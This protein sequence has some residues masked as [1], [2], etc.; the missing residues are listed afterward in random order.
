MKELESILGSND[1]FSVD[2]DDLGYISLVQHHVDSGDHTPIKQPPHRLSF[3]RSE[4]VSNLIDD[5]MKKGI[6][7]PSISAW[8]SLIVLVPKQQD[9]S[10]RFCVDYCKVNVTK[11]PLPRIDGI[12][13]T[14]GRSSYFTTLDLASGFW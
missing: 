14:L 1:V 7:Q 11:Y 2:D 6:I 9:N 12:L 10:V 4:T 3:S 8:A 13:D 5:V